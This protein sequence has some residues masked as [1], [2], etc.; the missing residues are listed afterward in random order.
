[1]T[2]RN[3]LNF[4]RSRTG[5]LLLFLLLLIIAYILVNGFKVPG[6]KYPDQVTN[7]GPEKP[8]PKSQVVEIVN[9]AMSAF[10]PPKETAPALA[11]ASV[12]E[13]KKS[14]N[15]PALPPISL[16]AESA[17]TEK[18]AEPL[19]DDYAPFGRLVQCELVITVDSSTIDTPIVGLVT[20][21]VWHNGRLIIPAG[22]EI[23]GTAKTDRVR[24]RIASSGNWTLVW[25]TGEELTVNGLALDREKENAEEDAWGITDGSAGLR[26]EL[27]K[28][29]N[30][31]EIKLF[32]STFLSGAAGG[33]TQTQQT[34]FGTQAVPSLQNAP[35]QG[36]QQVLNAYAK[37]ILD[38]IERDGFYVRVAAG[39]QFYLYVTQTIDKSKAV[40]GGTRLAAMK[41]AS[42]ETM[43]D[44]VSRFHNN[45]PR[46]VSPQD[47]VQ[48][49]PVLGV[50]SPQPTYR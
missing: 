30:L 33:M 21:D 26:G 4:F 11:S 35:F 41:K 8:A 20:E 5:A 10:N 45:Q 18:P 39:K 12:A 47:A 7:K 1:M 42:G 15:P 38:A 48:S 13:T 29:D 28:S 49:Q 36:A 6:V 17:A 37:Q 23:H 22:T 31:A 46:T 40:I 19:G 16:Y 44:S 24:E 2:P 27:L 3:F 50:N 32:V 43:D 25:Q 14:S 9:R 34:V